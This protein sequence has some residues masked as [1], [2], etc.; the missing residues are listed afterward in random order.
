MKKRE[1][2]RKR[3]EKER[4]EGN[5]ERE[6]E[7]R[8]REIIESKLINILIQDKRSKAQKKQSAARPEAKP[9]RR[10]ANASNAHPGR[11]RA[12]TRSAISV[13]KRTSERGFSE[14]REERVAEHTF[15]WAQSREVAHKQKLNLRAAKQSTGKC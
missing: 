11:S 15:E 10:A 7:E 2:K 9:R 3:G 13:F 5:R 4:E 6:R 14:S 1:Q 8:E 12:D